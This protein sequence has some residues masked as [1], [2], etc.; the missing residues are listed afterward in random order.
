MA[1]KIKKNI[2]LTKEKVKHNQEIE[3][4]LRPRSL[5]QHEKEMLKIIKKHCPDF[6]GHLLDIGCATG[7]NI[8]AMSDIWPDATYTGID[9]SDKLI[10]LAKKKLTRMN[11]EFLVTDIIEYAPSKKFDVIIASGILSCFDDFESVLDK[12]ISWLKDKGRLYIFGRFNSRN[13][14]TII[15]TRNRY[16]D[17]SWERGLTSY[18]IN[19]VKEYL[20]KKDLNYEFKQFYLDM[21]LAEQENPI[22]TYTV[23]CENGSRLIMNGANIVAEHFFL[24]IKRTKK[25]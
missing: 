10:R 1:N 5:K 3:S 11:A 25:N 14:D 9:I 12:W 15:Y 2:K 7:A 13:I 24:T 8:K 19:T 20:D 22:K 16:K 4:Y 6:N 17:G 21:D 23:R 18:S